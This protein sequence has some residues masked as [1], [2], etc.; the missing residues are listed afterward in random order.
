MTSSDYWD[1]DTAARYDQTSAEMFAPEVLDPTLAR[2]TELAEDGPVLEFASGTGR[3][4]IPLADNGIEV[5]GIELSQPM[6]DALHA[7]RPDLTVVVGDMATATGP[8]AGHYSLVFLV[9][10]TIGNL[11]TQ[12][13]QVACFRN[14]ARHLRPGGRFLI[15]VG[16]PPIR[17]FPPGAAAVPFDVSA[18]HIGFDTFDMATQQATSHHYSRQPDG[19]FRNGIHNYRY[20]WPAECDLMAQLAGLEP[21]SRHQ[22]WHGRAFTGDSQSHVSVWRKPS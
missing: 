11:C 13:E 21:E 10:N 19:S 3:V 4:S 5:D 9:F 14:A 7:K 2:L 12:P 1:A 22:D 16:V 6:T 18:A 20:L 17:R 15:E 8:R